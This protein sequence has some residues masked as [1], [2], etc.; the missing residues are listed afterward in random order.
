M[1]GGRDEGLI[2]LK[3]KPLRKVPA[4]KMVEALLE[5]VNRLGEE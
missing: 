5:E 4:G 1:A 2:F 3:G